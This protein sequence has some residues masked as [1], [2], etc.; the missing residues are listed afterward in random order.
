MRADRRELPLVNL[1]S[2]TLPQ[3][4][5][6]YAG[7]VEADL[8]IV[9]RHKMAQEITGGLSRPSKMPC[10]AWGLPAA[11]C[12]TGAVLAEVEGSTCSE[13][14]AK[15]GTFRFPNVQ[16]KLEE[17]FEG[18]FH[19]LWVP[20]MVFL[21]RWHADGYFR[22]F[23]SGDIQGEGHFN[24]ICEVARNTPDVKH[25]LPTREYEVVRVCAASIPEN[26]LVRVSAT[27]IDGTPPTWWPTTS[28]V[29]TDQEPGDGICGSPEQEHNC[30]SCRACW[31]SEVVNV[32]YRLH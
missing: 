15:G 31:D 8:R 19:P 13:C 1:A 2:A 29:I 20:A 26:L 25:W 9:S 32:A 23:D 4:V 10:P 24:N 22:W 3:A 21:I 18:I 17:R 30:Q 27:M 14:Y 16:D 28:T 12:R 7:D 11:R 5:P 6:L